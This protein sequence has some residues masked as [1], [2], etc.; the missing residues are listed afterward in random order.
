MNTK[1]LITCFINKN[2]KCNINQANLI[3]QPHPPQLEQLFANYLPVPLHLL[4]YLE[5]E[6]TITMPL[7][8]QPGQSSVNILPD[9][10]HCLHLSCLEGEL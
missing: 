5:G 6:V 8:L 9:P 3:C 10:L 1:Y 2:A 4:H 7:P